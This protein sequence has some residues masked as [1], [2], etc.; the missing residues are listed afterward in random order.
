[1][2]PPNEEGVKRR[3]LMGWDDIVPNVLWVDGELGQ[4]QKLGWNKREVKIMDKY[5]GRMK[6][7]VCCFYR[8]FCEYLK[9]EMKQKSPSDESE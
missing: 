8:I 7:K 4:G 1:M 5:G 3:K 2:G 9:W 6:R